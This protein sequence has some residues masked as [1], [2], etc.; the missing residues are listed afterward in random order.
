MLTPVSNP[1]S[2]S[3][4]SGNASTAASAT[5]AGPPKASRASSQRS[6]T[7]GCPT[8][9]TRPTTTTTALTSRN[10]ATSG[11][12][13]PTASL[14]PARNTPPRISSSTTVIATCWSVRNTGANGF[15]TKCAVASADDRVM[16]M[17]HDVATK[18]S[19]AS[20]NSLPHQNG[21][22]RSSMATEP[23]PFGLSAATRRY[24]GSI[25]NSVSATI[26]SVASGDTAPAASSAIPGR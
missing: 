19:R 14:N 8:A 6:T 1:D 13:T 3:T 24:I 20:T 23:W 11:T 9:Y 2:P 26:S 4:S 12:A 18:P 15:S 10:T 21:S 17:I 25:P 16:V 5:S 7:I 22:S